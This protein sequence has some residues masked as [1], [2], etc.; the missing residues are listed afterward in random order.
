MGVRKSIDGQI[1]MGRGRARLNHSEAS[2]R[3][4][5]ARATDKLSGMEKAVGIADRLG[6]D[7]NE[8]G[9]YDLVA[10]LL[11][12]PSGNLEAIGRQATPTQPYR[13]PAMP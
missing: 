9:C 6:I 10:P 5:R 1:R 8:D 4:R 3:G 7:R 11:S 12:P 2:S 13:I